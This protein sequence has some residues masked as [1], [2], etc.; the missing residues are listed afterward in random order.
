MRWLVCGGRD[1][2]DITKVAR[3]ENGRWDRISLEWQRFEKE[4]NFIITKLYELCDK[5]DL[6]TESDEYGN[7]L[8]TPFIISGAAKGVDTIA[9]EF[10]VVNFL[11]FAE[12]PANWDRYG[13]KAGYLRNVQ[14]LEEGKPDL[15]VAFPGGRGT[16]MMKDLARKK[17]VEVIEFV[18]ENS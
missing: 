9:I 2:A 18:W 4:R 5:Y 14:M 15:V 16:E 13:K 7:K 1:F 10:A 17:G 8:P 3:L 12:F 6:W 11:A